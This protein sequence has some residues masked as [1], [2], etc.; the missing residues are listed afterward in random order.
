[1][2]N[3]GWPQRAGEIVSAREDRNRDAAPPV[4][5]QRR[6]RKQRGERGRASSADQH[7]LCQRV[8]PQASGKCRGH[9]A[10]PER[11]CT[12]GDRHDD[13]ETIR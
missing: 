9:V 2:L 5:P 8:L 4:E 3:D 11:Y 1:M 13:P 6:V 10:K 12:E 7:T